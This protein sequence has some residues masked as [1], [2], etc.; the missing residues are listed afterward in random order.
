VKVELKIERKGDGIFVTGLPGK[1]ETV[2][3]MELPGR[4]SPIFQDSA[5]FIIQYALTDNRGACVIIKHCI[6]SVYEWG[7]ILF[8]NDGKI[9]RVCLDPWR[10]LSD[11]LY[12]K[13]RI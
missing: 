5:H 6:A 11:F 2:N 12:A 9:E 3:I 1:K 8:L 10:E 4:Q 7:K 13:S